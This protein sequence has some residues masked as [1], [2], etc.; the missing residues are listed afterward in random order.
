MNRVTLSKTTMH[1]VD[2]GGGIPVLLVH[3]F[4]L[5]HTMWAATI[6]ALASQ[7]RVI[8]PDLRGFGQTPLAPG[9]V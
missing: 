5:D 1:Y 4:P 7:A 3:G 2:R 6:D 8:A 9:D